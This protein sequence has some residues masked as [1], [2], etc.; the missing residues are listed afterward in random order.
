LDSKPVG[1][2]FQVKK[3]PLS[4]LPRS[5]PRPPPSSS[6]SSSSSAA[7]PVAA[8]T[9]AAA[10]QKEK[11]GDQYVVVLAPEGAKSE[12]DVLRAVLDRE[13]FVFLPEGGAEQVIIL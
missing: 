5:V 10:K 3:L 1:E 11:E 7:A 9:A 4:A 8:A 6:S 12:A 2:G 13:A